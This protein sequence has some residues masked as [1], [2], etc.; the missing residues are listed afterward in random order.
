MIVITG[1]SGAGKSTVCRAVRDEPG[2][3][4]I[5]GDTIA[6]GAAAVAGPVPDYIAF[7]RYVRTLAWE[8]HGNGLTLVIGCVCLP[9]QI[10]P[11]PGEPFVRVSALALVADGSELLDRRAARRPSD[12]VDR[13]K[14]EAIDAALRN[15]ALPPPHRYQVLETTGRAADSTI[16]AARLLVR[17]WLR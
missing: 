14:H 15:G 16:A 3:V 8:I 11:R 17:E 9:E 13:A 10:L 2:L 6:A 12:E 4:A 1:A 7:W 5:D